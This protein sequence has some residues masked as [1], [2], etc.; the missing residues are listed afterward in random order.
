MTMPPF[1]HPFC[2]CW[3][4]NCFLFLAIVQNTIMHVQTFKVVNKMS[5][6]TVTSSVNNE[7]FYFFPLFP[8]IIP[9]ISFFFLT[10]FKSLHYFT[11][12]YNAVGNSRAV[13][14]LGFCTFTA[15]GM[16]SI[17]GRGTKVL[18]AKWPKTQNKQSKNNVCVGLGVFS[19]YQIMEI[20]FYSELVSFL[21]HK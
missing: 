21:N 14:W 9:F 1:M 17:P 20:P 8:N 13:Q 18:Q 10:D 5:I 4:L 2:H 3:T 11:I 19:S 6:W 15:E 7:T 16:G 12:R